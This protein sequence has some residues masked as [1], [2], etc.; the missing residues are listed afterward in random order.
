MLAFTRAS[1][2]VSPQTLRAPLISAEGGSRCTQARSLRRSAREAEVPSP[3]FGPPGL[4]RLRIGPQ[5][6]AEGAEVCAR[7]SEPGQS[8]R[9]LGDRSTQHVERGAT[10]ARV[11]ASDPSPAARTYAQ[12]P[13]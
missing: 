3:G 11:P 1:L 6:R 7:A 5:G 10:A 2:F 13:S 9:P 4:E 8:P 12:S